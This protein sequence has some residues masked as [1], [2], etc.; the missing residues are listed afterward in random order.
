MSVILLPIEAKESAIESGVAK[1]AQTAGWTAKQNSLS[2]LVKDLSQFKDNIDVTSI[3]DIWAG[4]KAFEAQLVDGIEE[5]RTMWRA[6]LA[7]IGLRKVLRLSMSVKT[8]SIPAVGSE[9]YKNRHPFMQVVSRLLDKEFADCAGGDKINLLC[10][11]NRVFAMV[12]PNSLIYPVSGHNMDL[13]WWD[14]AKDGYQDPAA[15]AIAAE[16]AAD[17]GSLLYLSK[18]QSEILALWLVKLQTAVGNGNTATS[19]AISAEL[20]KYVNDLGYD[21]KDIANDEQAIA[22]DLIYTSRD[23]GFEIAGYCSML[24]QAYSTPANINDLDSSN[25]RLDS[26]TKAAD[27]V[28]PSKRV[29]VVDEAIAKQWGRQ[30]SNIKCFGAT[31]LGSA[32]EIVKSEAKKKQFVDDCQLSN[33]AAEIW[34][35]EDFFTPKI[36][37]VTSSLAFPNSLTE[38]EL[39]R[40]AF[41]F[42]YG[43]NQ[44]QEFILPIRKEVLEYIEA[45]D[46]VKN[47]QIE[48]D[49]AN[50]AVKVALT[51]NLSGCD[52][53]AGYQPVVLTKIYE[54]NDIVRSGSIP[55]VQIWPNFKADCWKQYY[56]FSSASS[57]GKM[58]IEPAWTAAAAEN[59]NLDIAAEEAKIKIRRGSEFPAV[60]TCQ[61]TDNGYR[62]DVGLICLDTAK[63]ERVR[64]NVNNKTPVIGVDFGTTNSVVYY[65][66][67]YAKGSNNQVLPE[68]LMFLDRNFAVTRVDE[69]ISKADLRRYFFS[70]G[71]QPET[72]GAI[73]SIRTIF[74]DFNVDVNKINNLEQPLVLGNIYYL[75]NGENISDDK[76]V[77]D[78]LNGNI[79]WD[80]KENDAK[81]V[82]R[83]HSFIYQI[84][85]QAMAEAVVSGAKEITWQYSWPTAY[86]SNKRHNYANF[87]S[88]Q[89]VNAMN[90]I[91][92]ISL[93]TRVYQ[94]TES[95]SMADYFQDG[96]ASQSQANAYSNGMITIDIGGGSTDIAIWKGLNANRSLNRLHQCSFRL[97]GTDILANYIQGK[98]KNNP[99]LLTPLGSNI[100][101]L[102]EKFNRL[103]ELAS[104]AKQAPAK[105]KTFELELES[106]LKY[107]EKEIINGMGVTAFAG[108]Q[109][110]E[111]NIVMRD[112]AFALGGMF[113]YVGTIIAYLRN[114]QPC[115]IEDKLPD[116]FVGGN[117]SKLLNWAAKGSFTVNRS[118]NELLRDCLVWGM[119][120]SLGIAGSDEMTNFKV[121]QSDKPKHE[122]AAGLI[123]S[124]GEGNDA[125]DDSQPADT[126]AAGGKFGKFASFGGGSSLIA[127]N[128]TVATKIKHTMEPIVAGESYCKNGTLVDSITEMLTAENFTDSEKYIDLNKDIDSNMFVR[129]C[130]VFNHEMERN[131]LYNGKHIAFASANDLTRIFEK[132]SNDLLYRRTGK[133]QSV[134][135]EP[136]FI[137]ELR[138]AL[139]MLSSY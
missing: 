34:T 136:I 14:A 33:F 31:D 3:P 128:N 101:S 89:L 85:L 18:E 111:L 110:Q 120:D 113:Y 37:Y 119:I 35:A 72:I 115:P 77:I 88:S 70:S 26:L 75:E 13:P 32:V 79:K 118:L 6:L 126:P 39:Y 11:N 68:Q 87:W 8:I 105:W 73:N 124:K 91:A 30:A 109:Y 95:M 64:N 43:K 97:A 29:L 78:E 21:V 50:G 10:C 123:C 55:N 122:V 107:S 102:K 108:A 52:A 76:V 24:S 82:Q 100:L 27:G 94:K 86:D 138:E 20:E 42:T 2:A 7:A 65:A 71:Q 49:G 93:T 19:Q 59:V 112:I 132:V 22:Q 36:A 12:W 5:Q 4:P 106:I 84:C 96:I 41:C 38:A 135:V 46:L 54:G 83:M 137:M 45:E 60:F 47:I 25:I 81:N 103:Q 58:L 92:D 121:E 57:V 98:Y 131:N 61:V 15:K 28:K 114:H 40:S 1:G 130:N 139:K 16:N 127:A 104:E 51:I 66:T 17:E 133:N 90:E 62:H 116:C 99:S 53:K 63:L 117:G 56:V 80:N 44:T 74:H 134:V 9:A 67:D 48:R 23:E 129:Y 69:S 125:L